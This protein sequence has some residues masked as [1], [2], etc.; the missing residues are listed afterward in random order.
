LCKGEQIKQ[1]RKIDRAPI[2]SFKGSFNVRLGTE[3][4][5]KAAFE[6]SRRGIS[7]N[8]LVEEALRQSI[9]QR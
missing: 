8:A 5:R 1:K 7:L 3:L 9:G 4:H 6:A 2:V